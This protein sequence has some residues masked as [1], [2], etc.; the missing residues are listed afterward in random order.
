M[1]MVRPSNQSQSVSNAMRLASRASS[2]ALQFAGP[3]GC[4]AWLD[5][6]IETSPWFLL[7]GLSIGSY[8]GFVEII[9]L[10][11]RIDS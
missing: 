5:Q 1:I 6:K 3:A 9:R 2:I 8:L 11:K 10:S 4:G 7:L